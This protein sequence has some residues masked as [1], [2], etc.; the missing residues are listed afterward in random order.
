MEWKKGLIAG[1]IAGILIIIFQYLLMMVPGYS[2]WYMITFPQMMTITGMITGPTSSLIMGIIIGL[3]YATINNAI[4]KKGLMKGISYGIMIW[5]LSGLMWPIM[6]MSFAPVYMWM[7]ELI[8]G[9]IIYLIVGAVIS[10]VY[11]KL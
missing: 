8:G 2:E 7:I 5:L 6:M 3:I 4:P 11:E 1:I 9:L 10:F